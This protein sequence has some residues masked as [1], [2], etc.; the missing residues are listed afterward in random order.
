M[1][2][3]KLVALTG[4]GMSAESGLQT[5]RDADGLWEGHEVQEVATPT[6]WQR[7]PE[8]VQR[9]YNERRQGVIN[10]RPNAGHTT[11][12]RL[13]ENFDVTIVTQNID[14]LHERAGSSSVLHLH[15]EIRKSQSS[16]NPF[17]VYDIEGPTLSM[18]ELCELG[19]QLRPHVVWFGEAVPMLEKAAEIVASSDILLV[20]GTSMVVYPAAG[21]IHERR[22]TTPIFLIDP[23]PPAMLTSQVHSS[24][25]TV[26]KDSA[27]RGIPELEKTLIKKFGSPL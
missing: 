7:D 6:A 26:I 18:G 5:F 8:L 4:A 25:L 9:F 23:S 20:V 22:Q 19:S 13:E 27:A 3:K 2:S 1:T 12:A 10:A 11:L 17:L 16:E 21:L 14:D 15:G 24:E